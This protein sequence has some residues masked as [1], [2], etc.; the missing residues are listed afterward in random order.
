MSIEAIADI[1]SLNKVEPRLIAV[2]TVNYQIVLPGSWSLVEFIMY[3]VFSILAPSIRLHVS[4]SLSASMRTARHACM[5]LYDILT[6]CGIAYT[7]Y[8]TLLIRN[9]ISA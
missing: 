1:S 5:N 4:E 2:H 8:F 7:A 9:H 6:T 3:K